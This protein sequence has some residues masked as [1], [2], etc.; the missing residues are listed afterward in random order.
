MLCLCTGLKQLI[1]TIRLALPVLLKILVTVLLL[2]AAVLVK[3]LFRNVIY[4]LVS[5]LLFET[6]SVHK[7]TTMNY[8]GNSNDC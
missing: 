3:L 4:D 5:K 2:G 8:I 1:E 7:K 6:C